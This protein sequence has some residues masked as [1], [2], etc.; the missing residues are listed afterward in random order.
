MRPESHRGFT[1]M[2]MIGVVAVI[3]ILAAMATPMIFDAIRDA[4]ISTFAADIRTLRTA[5]ARFYADTGTLPFH[6]PN[7]TSLTDDHLI[8]NNNI[9]GW[10]GPYVE[11][12]VLERIARDTTDFGIWPVNN[13]PNHFDLDGDGVRET[14]D[15]ALLFFIATNDED[16]RRL[17]DIIDGDGDVTSGDGAWYSAGQVARQSAASS[18]TSRFIVYL[19]A[20]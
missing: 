16:G 6:R 4:R 3:A 7:N 1:L 11:G 5:V 9:A 12:D 14:T 17:S 15:T 18:A 19:A 2:E 8:R 13:A 20:R 10:D